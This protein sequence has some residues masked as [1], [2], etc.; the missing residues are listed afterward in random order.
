MCLEKR[1][2]Q[3]NKTVLP[4]P[5]ISN[6]MP[7][8]KDFSSWWDNG[9]QRRELPVECLGCIA[10]SYLFLLTYHISIF[11]STSHLTGQL[12]LLL[13]SPERSSLFHKWLLALGLDFR[14]RRIT[15]GSR[16]MLHC[17]LIASLSC[18]HEQCRQVCPSFSSK[19][20]LVSRLYVYC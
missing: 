5:Q 14:L 8:N 4:H 7:K 10:D 9:A 11:P 12:Y 20:R 1:S 16:G 17:E 19:G 18:C 3:K 13:S 15:K 6:T 2:E